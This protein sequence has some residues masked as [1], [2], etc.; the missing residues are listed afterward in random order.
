MNS[1]LKWFDSHLMNFMIY[2]LL[3]GEKQAHFFKSPFHFEKKHD[4]L[5][6]NKT[7]NGKKLL[8]INALLLPNYKKHFE[9]QKKYKGNGLSNL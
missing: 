4:S 5:Y 3:F 9:A 1:N 7:F 2:E 6:N 8:R